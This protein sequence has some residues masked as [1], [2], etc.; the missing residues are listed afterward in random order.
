MKF[1]HARVCAT[2]L[3]TFFCILGCSHA[4]TNPTEAGTAATSK[5]SAE[6]KDIMRFSQSGHAAI[7]SIR[8]ARVAIFNGDPKAAK[9]AMEKAKSSIEAAEKEA[10]T[11]TAKTTFSVAGSEV[12]SMTDQHPV[13]FVPLDGQMALAEDYVATPE[14]QAHIDKANEHLKKGETKEA[15]DEL[16][17]AGVDVTYMRVW[18]PIAP[19]SGIWMRPSSWPAS[20]STMN[21]S[22]RSRPSKTA[23]S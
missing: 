9:E 14:K 11:F 13:A 21:R 6:A 17:L 12:G 16:K 19:R 18:M 10:P 23:W 2:A 22:W 8:E 3:I 4:K 7:E 1:V 5:Q 15:M 20:E